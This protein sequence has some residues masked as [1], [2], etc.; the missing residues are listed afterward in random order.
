MVSVSCTTI[1]DLNFQEEYKDH[2]FP[3][4]V[5]LVLCAEDDDSQINSDHIIYTPCGSNRT[6]DPHQVQN[7]DISYC[8]QALK[9]SA[10]T[11]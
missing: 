6:V 5:A 3:L 10:L 9:V 7:P 1:H 2:T 11:F 4:A 8:Y